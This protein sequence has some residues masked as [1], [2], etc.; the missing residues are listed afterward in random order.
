MSSSVDEQRLLFLLNTGISAKRIGDYRQAASCYLQA[1]EIAPQ[2]ARA[3]KNISKILIG[4]KE[5]QEA[6]RYLLMKVRLGIYYTNR[7]PDLS[8]IEQTIK[9]RQKQIESR[10]YC[11]EM[12]PSPPGN[13]FS[14]SLQIGDFNIPDFYVSSVISKEKICL[15][16]A[17]LMWAEDDIYYYI[18]HAYIKLFPE[19]FSHYNIPPENMEALE[20]KVLGLEHRCD[21]LRDSEK[22]GFVF[23]ITGFLICMANIKEDLLN[24]SDQI[25]LHS[26]RLPLILSVA[27]VIPPEFFTKKVAFLRYVKKSVVE[28]VENKFNTKVLRFGIET[29]GTNEYDNLSQNQS[30]LGAQRLYPSIPL[31]AMYLVWLLIPIDDSDNIITND[32]YEKVESQKQT[33]IDFCFRTDWNVTEFLHKILGCQIW[34]TGN[35]RFS[36]YQPSD[37]LVTDFEKIDGARYRYFRFFMS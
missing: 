29:K 16:I 20:L 17:K 24:D 12:D 26:I 27:D 32:Y 23:Y 19:L 9:I 14:D 30:V 35:K 33:D 5:Y 37:K 7:S 31:N 25:L 1:I 10:T 28:Q 36:E 3:Y 11:A 34:D 2:D 6:I 4:N 8:M 21:D 13:I 22:L 18:G 15:D